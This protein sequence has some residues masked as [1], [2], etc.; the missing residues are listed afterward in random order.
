MDAYKCDR[1]GKYYT[2]RTML[3]GLTLC[4]SSKS[5]IL[6][7]CEECKA[8]LTEWLTSAADKREDEFYE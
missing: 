2:N 7:L 6:D 5:R 4:K 1:C 3:I 8:S